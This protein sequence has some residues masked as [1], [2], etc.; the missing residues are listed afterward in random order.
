MGPGN[1]KDVHALFCR[2]F[3][4]IDGNRNHVYFLSVLV[5][6]YQ[7]LENRTRIRNRGRISLELKVDRSGGVYPRLKPQPAPPADC[8]SYIRYPAPGN[9]QRTTAPPE[10]EQPTSSIASRLMQ[11]FYI[12]LQLMYFVGKRIDLVF[13]QII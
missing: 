10:A 4:V 13:D 9:P 6:C 12:I 2:V 1:L 8:I 3:P 5:I 7:L 11:I